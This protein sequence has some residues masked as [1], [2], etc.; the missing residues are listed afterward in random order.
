MTTV[1]TPAVTPAASSLAST[2]V[3]LDKYDG[4]TLIVQ[5]WLKFM[6]FLSQQKVSEA[7]AINTLPFY[8]AGA[9]ESWFFFIR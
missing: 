6:T 3:K 2:K 4:K 8:L 7:V 1:T 5:W 9:A